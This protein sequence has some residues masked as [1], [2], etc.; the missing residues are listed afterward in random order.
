[1]PNIEP[2]AGG[3][4]RNH[5]LVVLAGMA[6]MALTTVHVYSMGAFLAPIE[7]EFAWS[8]SEITFGFTLMTVVGA[9][10]APFF[11]ALIDKVGPR[12]LGIAGVAIY[13]A[14]LSS[15]SFATGNVWT[16]WGLWFLLS[17]GGLFIKPTIW[18][19]AVSSLFSKGR[20]LALAVTL[21][22]TGIGSTFVP[23][24]SNYLINEFGWRGG[25][26]ALAGIC[27]A[28]VLPLVFF[29]LHSAKD[30]HR[31]SGASASIAAAEIL[32]G[33]T[34]REALLS[35]RFLKLAIAAFCVTLA[36]IS[37]VVNLIPIMSAN[38]LSRDT[39]VAIA[40]A[41]GITS[42]IGRLATG[43]LL[44][45]LNG[46]IIG[47][48][49]VLAPIFSCAC[50]LVAPQSPLVALIAIVVLGLALGAELDVV[51]Y[52]ATRHFGM[53]AYGTIF[54]TIVGL[55][56]VAT[57]IGPLGASFIYD[58]TGSYE[59]ALWL[60]IPLFLLASGALFSLGKYPEFETPEAVIE[61]EILMGQVAP[62]E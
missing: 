30:N 58:E 45:R 1:M 34:A 29:F 20:G 42:V 31:R 53:R 62:A 11:G 14:I 19:A 27:A 59:L 17:F 24:L 38:G 2:G 41:V 15:L 43:F 55:W 35:W 49:V 25:Y 52:L 60:Y 33:L 36:I 46:N 4:W 50:L 22:G 18:T 12:R 9:V 7:Q 10:M 51:A 3:E 56:A 13:C 61:E 32:P 37:F 39:A 8:R 44:D 23:I 26:V 54:G 57:G 5:G 16:W 47:G 21:C 48:I 40:G 6:G 28:I